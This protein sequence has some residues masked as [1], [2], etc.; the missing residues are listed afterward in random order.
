MA[1]VVNLDRET[2][3]W[4]SILGGHIFSIDFSA[5][6][7]TA[8]ELQRYVVAHCFLLITTA[9][10]I[11]LPDV[12]ARLVPA[13]GKVQFIPSVDYVYQFRFVADGMHV[14]D[15][16]GLFNN[17]R[18]ENALFNLVVSRHGTFKV[19]FSVDG[20]VK[21]NVLKFTLFEESQLVN[22]GSTL[23]GYVLNLLTN[24]TFWINIEKMLRVDKEGFLARILRGVHFCGEWINLLNLN[25]HWFDII[26][27]DPDECDIVRFFFP[28]LSKYVILSQQDSRH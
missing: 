15:N 25:M 5:A 13:L 18:N 11:P 17:F 3:A 28:R 8:K 12:T 7:K 24:M 4:H 10:Q 6:A 14:L 2:T 22:V 16:G 21:T 23:N 27:V 19:Y 20:T 9:L 26:G 1:R